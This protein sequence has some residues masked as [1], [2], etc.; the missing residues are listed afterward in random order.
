MKIKKKVLFNIHDIN[1][2]GGYIGSKTSYSLDPFYNFLREI[3]NIENFDSDDYYIDVMIPV[4]I[5]NGNPL[6]YVKFFCYYHDDL[7]YDHVKIPYDLMCDYIFN[8]GFIQRPKHDNLKMCIYKQMY[9]MTNKYHSYMREQYN[10]NTYHNL[11]GEILIKSMEV[12]GEIIFD[13][14]NI[15]SSINEVELIRL[16]NI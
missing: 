1:S 15:E 14:D 9:S 2:Y 5:I 10:N 4:E 6:V 7:I 11:D 13:M 3:K 12:N 16:V 8:F